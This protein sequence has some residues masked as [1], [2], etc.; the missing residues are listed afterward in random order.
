MEFEDY[1]ITDMYFERLEQSI[2]KDPSMYL[3]SHNRWK[4]TR[5][6]FEMRYDKET[7]KFHMEPIEDVIK[8]YEE[9]QRRRNEEGKE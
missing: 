9:R 4:R 1:R 6:E 7:G 3:W 8:Q 5:A 2:R